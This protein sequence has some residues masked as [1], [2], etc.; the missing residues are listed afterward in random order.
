MSMKK[1]ALGRSVIGG[2]NMKSFPAD[3]RMNEVEVL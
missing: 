1:A 2:G 3:L